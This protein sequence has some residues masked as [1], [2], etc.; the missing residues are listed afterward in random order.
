MALDLYTTEELEKELRKRKME[1]PKMLEVPNINLIR[2]SV[3]EYIDY[4]DSAEYCED[5]DREHYIFEDAIVAFY[6][7]KIWKWHNSKSS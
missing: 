7:N 2:Q 4:V 5:N 1:K 3:Q 6:G